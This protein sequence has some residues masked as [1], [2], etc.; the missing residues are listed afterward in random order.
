MALTNDNISYCQQIDKP[1]A[2]KVI[3]NPSA[4]TEKKQKKG[5]NSFFIIA[6]ILVCI[7][8]AFPRS[9][10]RG[11]GNSSNTSQVNFSN[12]FTEIEYKDDS[13][14][15]AVAAAKDLVKEKLKSPSTA[16][17]PKSSEYIVKKRGNDY[18]VLGYVDAQ[19]D[20]GAT[21]RTNWKATFTLGDTSGKQFEISNYEVTLYE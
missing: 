3:S 4:N 10:N 14:G 7:F 13:W 9:S 15:F 8:F 6:V 2:K 17:F 1:N 12:T 11:N 16:K 21:V 20:F 18:I 19:N 5:N